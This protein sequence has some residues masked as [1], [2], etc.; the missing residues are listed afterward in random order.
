MDSLIQA[1]GID[2]RLITIQVINFVVLAAILSFFLYKPV[3]KM[4]NDREEKIKQ[5]LSDAEAAAKA[6]E[7][8]EE[9]RKGIVQVAH[10]EAEEVG[11]R[12]EIHAKEQATLVAAQA[13]ASA[14]ERIRLAED[15]AAALA[16][17]SKKQNE[18]EIAKLAVL[19]AEKIL[20]EAK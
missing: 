8:A 7:N 13:E 9:E 1:F 20:K 4:L 15:R 3:L 14:A 5:G 10:K 2:I 19:A 16:E 12:A 11:K 18:A 6:K 17:E